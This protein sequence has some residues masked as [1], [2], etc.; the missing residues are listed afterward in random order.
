MA[1]THWLKNYFIYKFYELFRL[2]AK[3]LTLKSKIQF[4]KQ[5]DIW[6]ENLYRRDV[7]PFFRSLFCILEAKTVFDSP[8]NFAG[9]LALDETSLMKNL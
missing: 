4:K 8:D 5:V 2:K 3:L 9:F 1:D 7:K 6:F